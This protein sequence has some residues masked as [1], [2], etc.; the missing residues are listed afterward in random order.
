[1]NIHGI[2]LIINYFKATEYYFNMKKNYIKII[3]CF[4][5]IFTIL[6]CFPAKA[7]LPLQGKTIVVDAGHGFKDPGTTYKDIYEKDINLSIAL[8]LEKHLSE[9]GATVILT[10]NSDMDLSNGVKNHRKKTDFDNRIKIINKDYVDL[11]LSIHLNYLSNSKYY[12][13][14]V[15]YNNDNKE[16]ANTIQN[17]LNKYIKSDRKIKKIPASTYM[18]ERLKKDGV[19][20]ECGFLSN[21]AERNKLIKD[22]YQNSLAK[23]IT[24]GVVKYFS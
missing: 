9:M 17:T 2:Y 10:R 18:Y 7:E 19:L 4:F 12:G 5:I 24:E 20:I 11:Y 1:M 8:Y 21:S 3:S 23:Y 13:P 16:L 14:Q 22:E 6:Y 15:F